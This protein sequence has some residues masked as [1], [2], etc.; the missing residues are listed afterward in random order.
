MA[1]FAALHD[2]ISVD[3]LAVTGASLRSSNRRLWRRHF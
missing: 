1:K 3:V 2:D